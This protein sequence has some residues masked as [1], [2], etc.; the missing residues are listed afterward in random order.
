MNV[1]SEIMAPTLSP[2][3]I[4]S[5]D[6]FDVVFVNSALTENPNFLDAIE[7]A[8]GTGRTTQIRSLI[9][10]ASACA[11]SY[12]ALNSCKI[13]IR[14]L[15]LTL[16]VPVTKDIE[17]LPE[18]AQ[19]TGVDSALSYVGGYCV[20]EC[21]KPVKSSPLNRQPEV[22]PSNRG[23]DLTITKADGIIPWILSLT[24][25]PAPVWKYTLSQALISNRH[26]NS[27]IQALV[28]ASKFHRTTKEHR[29]KRR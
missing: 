13:Q 24:M 19:R 20:V 23:S 27:V 22:Y 6:R 3:S 2:N 18:R 28:F 4:L 14:F 26:E 11:T 10:S 15:D 9:W 17:P 1:K 5:E 29:D 25:K 7:R 8:S 12:F 16:L 21:Q